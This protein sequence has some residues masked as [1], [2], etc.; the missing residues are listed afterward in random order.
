VSKAPQPIGRQ[1]GLGAL[2]DRLKDYVGATNAL[3]AA[4]EELR[5]QYPDLPPLPEQLGGAQPGG[6]IDRAHETLTAIVDRVNW[7]LAQQGQEPEPIPEPQPPPQPPAPTPPR[8]E[9][10]LWHGAGVF[11]EV[12]GDIDPTTLARRLRDNH[13]RWCAP[14]IHHGL[15]GRNEAQLAGGWLQPFREAGIRVGG[16]G[17]NQTE[18]EQEAAFVAG[19]VG[20]YGLDFYFANAEAEYEAFKGD[21]SRSARFAEAFRARLPSLPAAVSSY[22]RADM[23]AIDW[24]AWRDRGFHFLPQAYFNEREMWEPGLCVEGAVKAGWPKE[25]VHPTIGAHGP[26]P[27]DNRAVP[28]A[29]YAARLQAAGTVGFSVFMA[30]H[31]GDDEYR[32]LGEAIVRAGVAHA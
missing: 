32:Q 13:F 2:R 26:R 24:P 6:A 25:M 30:H 9:P 20:Q 3:L 27:P 21:A 14:M 7:L 23:E 28:P 4:L 1:H 29:D 16:W 19:L 18:P 22:G 5:T 11:V 10:S 31:Y 17:Y 8:A 15:E 12:A